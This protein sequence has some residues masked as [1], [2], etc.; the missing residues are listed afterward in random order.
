MGNRLSPPAAIQET[1]LQ[2]SVAGAPERVGARRPFGWWGKLLALLGLGLAFGAG[3]HFAGQH[4]HEHAKE[5]LPA[6]TG[7]AEWDRA[8]VLVTV[9][10]VTNRPV[11]R[12]VEAVGTLH[13]FEEIALA[14]RVEGRVRQLRFEVADVVKPGELLL[15]IDPVD[16]DLAVQQAERAL[17]VELAKLGLHEPPA[18]DIDLGAVPTVVQARTRMENAQARY[19]RGRR[20]LANQAMA[21]EEVGNLTAD[22]RAAQA[23]HANQLLVARTALAT[24]R[25]KQTELA[26]AQQRLKDTQVRV[27]LPRG[28][29]AT[30]AV[31]R[32]NVSEGTLVQPGTEVCKLIV[33]QTLKLRVPVPERYGPEV[34]A[35]QKVEV[36]AAASPQP[37]AGVVTRI[38]PAV[39]PTTRTF[40]VEIQV[41][42]PQ[43]TL[44][45]GGFAKAAIFTRL[46]AAAP[47]VP[48]AG[49]VNFAGVN[50]VF[51]AENGRA[52]EV[53]VTLGVQTTDWVEIAKPALPAGVPVITSGQ[54][55]LAADTPVTV[56]PAAKTATPPV[57]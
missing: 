11:Q 32:R 22:F 46:D 35:D 14:S 23:E 24:V 30:Y 41:P 26:V 3:W 31:T 8:T 28:A 20:L 1:S 43:G 10:P 45:P 19:E 27:P 55:V 15:E 39:E 38:N 36:S 48:L 21:D 54:T 12:T 16:C 18:G 49:V 52:R 6:A 56:S 5:A 25:M 47:T 7:L 57:R 53:P 51:L 44:K 33:N 2:Q 13:A 42:N 50:K 37:V 34:K 4:Q 9:A 40:E 17:L 29:G